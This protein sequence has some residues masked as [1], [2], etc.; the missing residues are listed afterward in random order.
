[1]KCIFYT[2]VVF[3][4][5]QKLPIKYETLE[6]LI[7][8]SKLQ[9]NYREGT[10]QF[11]R[12][13]CPPLSSEDRWWLKEMRMTRAEA[14]KQGE[15]FVDY[16]RY[17]ETDIP[18]SQVWIILFILK[19]YSQ[20]FWLLFKTFQFDMALVQTAFFS[21]VINPSYFGG[22]FVTDQELLDLAYFWRVAGYYLGLDDK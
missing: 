13:S 2:Y 16:Q 9:L 8:P 4:I 14:K 17:L 15:E 6:C 7:F 22:W 3:I 18:F 12:T 10:I 19:C 5:K 20:E 1:M 11:L 21:F